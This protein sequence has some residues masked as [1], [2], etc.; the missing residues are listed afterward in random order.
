MTD[1]TL[2][3]TG[4]ARAS[5]PDTSHAAAARQRGG[6]RP[7][8]LAAYRAHGPMC[9][10]EL[11]AVLPDFYPPTVKSARTRLSN[12]GFLVDTGDRRPSV[13]GCAQIVW[14]LV[15]WRPTQTVTDGLGRVA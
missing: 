9:D 13:R 2:F 14:A 1:L 10:D 8:I 7:A 15:P 4:A 6:A 12:D 5:D 11:A 3:D